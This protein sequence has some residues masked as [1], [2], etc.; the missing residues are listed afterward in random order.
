[1]NKELENKIQAMVDGELSSR[2]R[3]EF[4]LELEKSYPEHWRTLA[5]GFAE[6][7]LLRDA[8]IDR[9]NE[10]KG[11]I[12][13]PAFLRFAAILAVGAF[14]GVFFIQQQLPPAPAETAFAQP[15]HQVSPEEGVVEIA[16]SR[17]DRISDAVTEHGFHPVIE[18]TLI[19]A[20]LGEGRRLII[21]LNRLLIASND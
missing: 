21:P 4:L 7:Q 13:F 3:K 9:L 20:D 8:L 1:M 11:P 15:V 10:K 19:E 18:R 12:V 16:Q 17:I 5:L 6:R 2:A 14:L